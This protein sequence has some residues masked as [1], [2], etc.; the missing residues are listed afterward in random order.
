MERGGRSE[1]WGAEESWGRTRGLAEP[2]AVSFLAARRTRR[3][4]GGREHPSERS[5]SYVSEGA[6]WPT[7][8]STVAACRL[9]VC[10][11]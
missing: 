8:A 5:L 10:H 4:Q 6:E 11:A 3:G 7:P 9:V 2:E 1:G